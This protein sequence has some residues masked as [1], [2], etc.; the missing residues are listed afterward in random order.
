M[1]SL[2]EFESCSPFISNLCFTS[3]L[4]VISHE[5]TACCGVTM[6][7]CLCAPHACVSLYAL[8]QL[9]IKGADMATV[10]LSYDITTK[11]SVERDIT[12]MMCTIL[13]HSWNK[14]YDYDVQNWPTTNFDH[15]P[16]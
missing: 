9:N 14:K 8:N 16:T 2:C 11:I 1:L 7:A 12:Q 10:L 4:V 3:A 13:L 5:S 6:Q 15:Y